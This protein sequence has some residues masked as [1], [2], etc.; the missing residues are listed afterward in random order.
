MYGNNVCRMLLCYSNSFLRV[1]CVSVLYVFLVCYFPQ[2]FLYFL[3]LPQ[4]QGSL[5]PETF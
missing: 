4:G 2:H 3:P 5:R 1:L